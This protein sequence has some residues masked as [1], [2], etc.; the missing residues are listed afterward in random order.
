MVKNPPAKSGDAGLI[1]GLE[2]SPR[3]RNS[4]SF[5]YSCLGN[6]MD[7]GP[8]QVQSMGSQK[9][10]TRLSDWTTQQPRYSHWSLP[11]AQE[12]PSNERSLRKEKHKQIWKYNALLFTTYWIIRDIGLIPGSGRS[13]WRRKWHPTPI[14]LPGKFHGHRSLMGYSPR[15]LKELD[16]TKRLSTYIHWIIIYSTEKLYVFVNRW[17]ASHLKVILHKT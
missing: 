5:Q 1:S 2:R 12:A 6:P 10:W 9:S 13:P 16:M 17:L 14:F 11:L 3:E 7:R 8:W 15:G 4:T